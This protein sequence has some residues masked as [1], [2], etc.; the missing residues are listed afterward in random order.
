[1][2]KG[3]QSKIKGGVCNIPVDCNSVCK[4]LPRPPESSGIILLKLK[5]KLQ[6]QGHQYYDAVRPDVVEH[7]LEYLKDNN[8]H[9]DCIDIYMQNIDNG[10]IV[11]DNISDQQIS[12]NNSLAAVTT[13]NPVGS[14]DH[15][16]NDSDK[17]HNFH[18]ET[19]TDKSN[20]LKN[21]DELPDSDNEEIEDPHNQY[22]NPVRET[23]MQ[24][25]LPNYPI[26]LD[27][28]D[29]CLQMSEQ[30]AH[31]PTARGNEVFSIAPGEGRHPVHFMKDKYCE[32]MA[33]PTLFPKGKFGYQ[34]ERAVPLSPTKYFNARLLNY[35]G[36]FSSNPEYLFFAQYITEQKKCRIA[37]ALL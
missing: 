14:L 28:S 24:S 26:N 5:R 17:T 25:N 9:Y 6:Y 34:I 4:S 16:S 36:R 37:S 10:L 13:S 18:Q 21:S 23:C 15:I 31:L 8:I 22:R 20:N 33:F 1:M 29:Q 12:S 27:N 19:E 32:E 30:D 7:A 3:M 35:T 11:Q 2:P